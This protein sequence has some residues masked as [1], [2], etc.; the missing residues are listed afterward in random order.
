MVSLTRHRHRRR[1]EA[2]GETDEETEIRIPCHT[3]L[4]SLLL[5][6]LEFDCWTKNGLPSGRWVRDRESVTKSEEG[7]PSSLE[8]ESEATFVIIRTK[9]EE[10][11]ESR[12]RNGNARKLDRIST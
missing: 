7:C 2:D 9:E 10:E 6:L 4:T 11:K 5:L 8:S 3:R 1:G 12:D